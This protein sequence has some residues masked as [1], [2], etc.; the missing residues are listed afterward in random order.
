MEESLRTR[1][2]LEWSVECRFFS[3]EMLM[4]GKLDLES[5]LTDKGSTTK[6]GSSVML[7]ASRSKAFPS[8]TSEMLKLL[9][10]GI[11]PAFPGGEGVEPELS[12]SQL[13]DSATWK[14]R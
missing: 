1:C 8:A 5:A 4:V 13:A 12:A 3:F 9:G 7:C 6:A 11:L 14:K 2:T 10:F